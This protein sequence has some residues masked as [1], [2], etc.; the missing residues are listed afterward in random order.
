[1]R[2]LSAEAQARCLRAM[3][4]PQAEAE[5][6]GRCRGER[7]ADGGGEGEAGIGDELLATCLVGGE[8]LGGV[9]HG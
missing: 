6:E 9:R 5:D 1:M 2:V 4:E 3:G 8:R 7:Y